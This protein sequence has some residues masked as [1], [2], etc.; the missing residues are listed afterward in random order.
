MDMTNILKLL[1]KSTTMP[2]KN[3]KYTALIAPY[4]PVKKNTE[5]SSSLAGYFGAISG[6]A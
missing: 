1:L 5:G 4:E 3:I 2:V 6:A